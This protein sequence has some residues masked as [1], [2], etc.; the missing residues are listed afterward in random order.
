MSPTDDR[1][2]V[3]HARQG[4]TDQRTRVVAP[5]GVCAL[6]LAQVD[7]R[8]LFGLAWQQIIG[9]SLWHCLNEPTAMGVTAGQPQYFEMDELYSCMDIIN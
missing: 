2:P 7:M 3:L 5:A 6:L 4:E 8:V 9:Q 1:S